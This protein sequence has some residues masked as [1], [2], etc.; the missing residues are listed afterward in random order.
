MNPETMFVLRSATL[1][2]ELDR[3]IKALR[4]GPGGDPA[5][6]RI[7]ERLGASLL[8]SLEAFR[9][10]LT[11]LENNG[12]G[13]D[14]KARW[15][16]LHN[17]EDDSER[18]RKEAAEIALGIAMR[19]AGLDGGVCALADALIVELC[20]RAS[21]RWSG[22]T[23]I[24][25][26][27]DY[28]DLAETIRLR[29]RVRDIWE[30][31]VVAHEFGHF[32]R[33]HLIERDAS[34]GIH[35][36][37]YG[38]LKEDAKVWT[39]KEPRLTWNHVQEVFADVCAV[40]ALGPTFARAAVFLVF[41]PR[42]NS[43]WKKTHPS[44]SFR[45]QVICSALAALHDGTERPFYGIAGE[46]SEAWTQACALAGSQLA[47]DDELP[48]TI[49][50]NIWRLLGTTFPRLRYV[51]GPAFIHADALLRTPHDPALLTKAPIGE[52][53]DAA[54]KAR[55]EDPRSTASLA[56]RVTTALRNES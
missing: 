44:Y 1:G 13:A 39:E 20:N 38:A 30:L 8:A 41:D 40:H 53:L 55:L 18:N 19:A 56:E 49:V 17:L 50:A 32:L 22:M 11:A 54:W 27:H 25:P 43:V 34:F 24:G 6:M 37:Y 26:E 12:R 45:V 42:E 29:S 48:R 31:P 15:G 33:L 52:V 35:D 28:R 9:E 2:Q 14:L 47:K 23:I 4:P 3:S 16:A 51:R 36:S 46:L 5:R 7:L 21:L 10:R